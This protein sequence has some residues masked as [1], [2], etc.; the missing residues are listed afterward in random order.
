MSDHTVKGHTRQKFKNK[1]ST[2]TSE[3]TTTISSEDPSEDPKENPSKTPINDPK[4]SR[5]LIPNNENIEQRIDKP[6]DDLSE[7]EISRTRLHQVFL[8]VM[9]FSSNIYT[10]KTDWLPVT[11]VGGYK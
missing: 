3:K 1:R 10:D 2:K 11:S 4:Y 6:T 7:I 8:L 9:E 5:Y